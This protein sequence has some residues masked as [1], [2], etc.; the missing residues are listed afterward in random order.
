MDSVFNLLQ[1]RWDLK[2]PA[3]DSDSNYL[4]MS[5]V[6]GVKSFSLERNKKTE[7]CQVFLVDSLI[8]FLFVRD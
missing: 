1:N 6:G 3:N 8:Y 5:V 7:I 4:I 2:G